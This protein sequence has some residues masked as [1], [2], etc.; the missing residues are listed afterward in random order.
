MMYCDA[1]FMEESGIRAV[2][3]LTHYLWATPQLAPAPDELLVKSKYKYRFR[4]RSL[5][6]DQLELLRNEQ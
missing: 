4:L 5:H 2:T 1:R 3:C 6:M